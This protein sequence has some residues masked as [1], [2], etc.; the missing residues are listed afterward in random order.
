MFACYV[1]NK[2]AP[3]LSRWGNNRYEKAEL[4]LIEKSFH[5]KLVVPNGYVVFVQSCGDLFAEQIPAEWIFRVLNRILEFP[6]TTFLLQSKNPARFLDFKILGNC[7][8]G[9]TLESNRRYLDT[10]A[11]KE[12]DRLAAMQV[13]T[14]SFP[15]MVSIEPVRDFDFDVFVCWIRSLYPEFVSVGADSGKNGLSE[16]P[17]WKLKKLLRELAAFTEVRVKDSLERLLN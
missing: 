1:E 4:S 7:L 6:Q 14:W 17:A 13:L 10:H 11:P 2:I 3:M 12:T 5:E 8:L 9:T 16:P 15:V